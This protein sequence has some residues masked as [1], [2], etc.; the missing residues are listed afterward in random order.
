MKMD[1]LRFAYLSSWVLLFASFPCVAQTCFTADDM[2]AAT[3]SALQSTGMRY[4]GMVSRGDSASLK[5][6][7]IPSVAND[8]TAIENTIK[9]NQEA[10]AGATATPRQPFQLKAEGT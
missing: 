7:S 4:F 6:N 3:R 1:R 5:Q 2:N 8:F 10:L 9:D